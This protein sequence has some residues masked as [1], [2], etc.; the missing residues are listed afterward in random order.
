MV[1]TERIHCNC[2]KERT[3]ILL[4]TFYSRL[5][6]KIVILI[7][8]TVVSYQYNKKVSPQ[9]LSPLKDYSHGLKLKC[10]W[11]ESLDKLSSQDFRIFVTLLGKKER[12]VVVLN[13]VICK[14]RYS[15]GKENISEAYKSYFILEIITLNSCQKSCMWHIYAIASWWHATDNSISDAINAN[16]HLGLHSLQHN[17]THSITNSVQ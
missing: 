17:M 13:T 5:S 8:N 6:T 4:V 1:K 10:C 16:T 12:T 2:S 11:E 9:A 7:M 3:H 15:S 14:E